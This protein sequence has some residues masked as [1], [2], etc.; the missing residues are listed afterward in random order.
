[1]RLLPTGSALLFALFTSVAFAQEEL[2]A[3]SGE[4]ETFSR[5]VF[6]LEEEIN[7]SIEKSDRAVRIS[8]PYL[9]ATLSTEGLL[10][11]LPT[12][13]LDRISTD[14]G[15][16]ELQL[17]CDCDVEVFRFDG[18]FVV[19]DVLDDTSPTE[20]TETTSTE[21]PIFSFGGDQ[22][23][24]I[25]T[26]ADRMLPPITP[27]IDENVQSFSDDVLA[28]G[29]ANAVAA[30]LLAPSGNLEP[31]DD[32]SVG[33]GPSQ[34]EINTPL[35]NQPPQVAMAQQQICSLPAY[36]DIS[37]WPPHK[38]VLQSIGQMR[39]EIFDDSGQV[40]AERARS[41]AAGYIALGFGAEAR[42]I[43]EMSSQDRPL[44]EALAHIV[45]GLPSPS[46]ST[47]REAFACP[48]ALAFWAVLSAGA[49]PDGAN[50]NESAVE[51]T[52]A[53]M[54][55]EY[56]NA[57]AG[58]VAA[59][60]RT[61]G[62]E[63]AARQIEGLM[64]RTNG[65][66]EGEEEVYDPVALAELQLEDRLAALRALAFANTPPSAQALN[67]LLQEH[68]QS[69]I[70]L[71]DALLTFAGSFVET[72][73]DD[74]T[75][76]GIHA[77]LL[78]GLVLSGYPFEALQSYERLLLVQPEHTMAHLNALV[79]LATEVVPADEFALFVVG[80]GNLVTS[81]TV[82]TDT[83]LNVARRMVDVG[84]PSKALQLM[85]RRDLD[86]SP[87]K[88]LISARAFLAMG[89]PLEALSRVATLSTDEARQIRAYA[90][91]RMG[92][93]E[94]AFPYLAEA[95]PL[96]APAGW[97]SQRVEAKEIQSYPRQALLDQMDTQSQSER[98]ATMTMLLEE[99]SQMRAA[100]QGLLREE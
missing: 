81:D 6:P 70:A 55:L 23:N 7:W 75:R 85:T 36:A 4:H 14:R 56:R 94:E 52:L 99:T 87:E 50:L 45:D 95:D 39:R 49:L 84:M 19:I 90:Y 40:D 47:L 74:A 80:L 34:I 33:D 42:A 83:I 29:M 13:R 58:K 76:I 78:S 92:K 77:G 18:R 9:D 63:N 57:Y 30:Q 69:R 53:K 60:L 24:P 22:P 97:I 17:G 66:S 12:G 1:M 62:Y 27:E 59:R 79:S 11:R 100:I 37:Q 67:A 46:A 10:S 20:P 86:Q 65:S 73:E 72:V 26:L 28:S 5:I 68:M 35:R 64:A 51:V 88:R 38:D 2:I 82:D 31:N 21:Q 16:V 89:D 96:H 54:S 41:L 44:M 32:V 61:G 15:L 48:N 43:L 25:A 98:L 8:F 91:L 71:D 93:Y 3:Q